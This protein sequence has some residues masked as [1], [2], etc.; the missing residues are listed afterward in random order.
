MSYIEIHISTQ[1]PHA[2]NISNQLTLLGALAVTL[3]D[4]GDQPIYEPDANTPRVWDETT[5]VGLFDGGH[6]MLP[7]VAHFENQQT[8]GTVSHFQLIPV[9]DEDW[10][11]RSLDSFQPLSFGKRL[12]ICPSWH[13]PP[14]PAACNVMLDPGLAF[15]T[16][17]HP[18]TA[19]CLEWL[20]EHIT[21]DET[22]IDYGCG[23][24]ILGIA[25]VKLGAHHVTA[26]DHD[27]QALRATHD[28]A[29]QNGLKTDQL[30]TLSSVEAPPAPADTVI[31]NILANPLIKLAPLLAELTKKGGKL[32]LS[33]IL[34]NQ[35][36]EVLTAYMPFFTLQ[37]IKNR[38]EWYLMS[39]I[40]TK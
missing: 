35:V 5:V 3:K 4:A 40:K 16:G 27:A 6:R 34:E 20:D 19:L 28:N 12:W 38:S 23:S 18:T 10:V 1:A 36:I 33:G 2:D 9:A 31:A 32:A 39:F 14:D 13:T 25:A 7:L 15:G 26:I 37:M 24:G 8:E 17:S 21:L 30:E 22:V 11:R 29:A